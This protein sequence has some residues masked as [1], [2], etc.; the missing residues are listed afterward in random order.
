MLL[1]G[2]S[3]GLSGVA[4]GATL[5]TASEFFD[6]DFRATTGTGAS[7]LLIEVNVSTTPVEQT[8]GGG[9]VSW[10]HSAAGR[11]AVGVN[12]GLVSAGVEL[13]N[14]TETTGDTLVFGR[15]IQLDGAGTLLQNAV[16]TALGT[17]VLSSWQSTATISNMTMSAGQTYALTVDV[18]RGSVLPVALL[19]SSTIDVRNLSGVS[20][21]GLLNVINLV[22]FG[23]SDTGTAVIEFTPTADLTGMEV[24]FAASAALD[25]SLLSGTAGNENMLTF[26]GIEVSPIPEPSTV[27]F[28]AGLPF[29]AL[30]RRK[31]KW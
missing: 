13:S 16:S 30:L 23:G 3:L 6:P 7:G 12:L 1:L 11:V 2:G 28:L 20:V 15:E 26:S 31:R 25:G 24:S 29:L 21:S 8:L 18:T 10:T 17:S 27:G 5:I 22:N 9:N 14:F 4:G 19:N